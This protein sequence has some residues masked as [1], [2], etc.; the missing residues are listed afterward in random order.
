VSGEYGESHL[1]SM[2]FMFYWVI[3]KILPAVYCQNLLDKLAKELIKDR[4]GK[5]RR[6][7]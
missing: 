4:D 6:A 5:E 3:S 1:T 2:I 7:D